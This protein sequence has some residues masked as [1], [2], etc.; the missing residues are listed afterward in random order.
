MTDTTQGADAPDDSALFEQATSSTPETLEKFENP[1]AIP[2]TPAPAAPVVEKPADKPEDI[3]PVPSGRFREEMEARRRAERERDE[4][5]GMLLAQQRQQPQKPEEPAKPD[6]FENPSGFVQQEL[7]PY[8]DQIRSDFQNQREAMSLDWAV[9]S[10]GGETVSQA[11]QYLE[12][13]MARGDPN[14]WS[15]YN[16]AMQSH[17][18]YGVIVGWHREGEVLRTT[19]GDLESYKKRVREEALK[20]PEFRKQALELLRG[21]AQASGNS[22]ARPVKPQSSPSLGDIGAGGRDETVNEPSDNELFRA[23]TSAKRR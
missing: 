19:G 14:A 22:V 13:G 7:R 9:R 16:R 20:D 4:L 23:A 11:R 3:T 21:E 2:E 17:D 8:L 1:P 12:Q 6:F 18:P 5:R 10:H 15:T